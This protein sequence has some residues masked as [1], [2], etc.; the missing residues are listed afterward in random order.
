[1]VLAATTASTATPGASTA[2]TAVTTGT[3]RSTTSDTRQRSNR[4][5][6]EE[7]RGG[8]GGSDFRWRESFRSLLPRK[9]RPP[10]LLKGHPAHN[11]AALEPK[12]RVHKWPS[13][14]ST[15]RRGG[16][17]PC[18]RVLGQQRL[19]QGPA[20]GRQPRARHRRPRRA[21]RNGSTWRRVRTLLK[22]SGHRFFLSCSTTTRRTEKTAPCL[23]CAVPWSRKPSG[24]A[25]TGRGPH[26]HNTLAGPA[27]ALQMHH[28]HTHQQPCSGTGPFCL[29]QMVSCWFNLAWG[30][31]PR[32][33][34]FTENVVV[35]DV[36]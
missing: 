4:R 22:I 31:R 26:R 7:G 32:G 34:V 25:I 13:F 11:V 36:L 29:N 27:H 19:V 33:K 21:E 6:R 14:A 35:I 1:M 15:Y 9:T 17:G 18:G 28:T 2:T 20:L 5:G 23:Q 8:G 30:R 3:Y 24:G 10:W 16:P 12:R